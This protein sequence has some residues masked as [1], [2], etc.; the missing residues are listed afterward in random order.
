MDHRLLGRRISPP[1]DRLGL[2]CWMAYPRP[3]M[4]SKR[5]FV[6]PSSCEA[7]LTK[8]EEKMSKKRRLKC[9]KK[10]LKAL[11]KFTRIIGSGGKVT[12]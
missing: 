5:Q 2:T 4:S 7:N 8:Q 12:K 6:D 3:P 9:S 10:T 11:K 1:R